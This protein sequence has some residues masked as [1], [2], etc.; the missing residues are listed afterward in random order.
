MN[1]PAPSRAPRD[2]LTLDLIEA[3]LLHLMEA[4]KPPS[5]PNVRELLG[6]SPNTIHPMIQRWFR[7]RA[8]GLLAGRLSVVQSSDLPAAAHALVAE[9]RD[10]ARRAADAALAE[11]LAKAHAIAAEAKGK[12]DAIAERER[13]VVAEES[14]L[15]TLLPAL[16]ADL[17]LIRGESEANRKAADKAAQD[18]REAITDRDATQ[19][20]L[21]AAEAKLEKSE[22]HLQTSQ[23]TITTLRDELA[24]ARKDIVA[25]KESTAKARAETAQA[26]EDG[27][28][29]AAAL[30]E[31]IEEIKTAHLREVQALRQT[32]SDSAARWAEARAALEKRIAT[33]QSGVQAADARA[34]QAEASVARLAMERDALASRCSVAEE[35]LRERSEQEGQLRLRCAELEKLVTRMPAGVADLSER[36]KSIEQQLASLPKD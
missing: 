30:R 9:L 2:P 31:S 3:A 26:K 6:G 19:K 1:H 23:A 7:E 13:R 20:M 27:A 22:G 16:R 17:Q 18:R 36:I 25:E 35:A 24:L 33:L 32:Q 11:E 28:K 10:D 29:T 4:G 15:E 5:E 8:P 21:E 12:E 14:R 34:V